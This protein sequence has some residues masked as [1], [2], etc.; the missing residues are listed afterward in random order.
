MAMPRQIMPLRSRTEIFGE[1]GIVMRK[2]SHRV[3]RGTYVISQSRN[4]AIANVM[5]WFP[6]A[7]F[8]LRPVDVDICIIAALFVMLMLFF[9]GAPQWRTYDDDIRHR[10]GAVFATVTG[11]AIYCF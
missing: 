10:C 5:L 8:Q 7:S 9:Q 6:P 1:K 2:S 4:L 3:F 11:T